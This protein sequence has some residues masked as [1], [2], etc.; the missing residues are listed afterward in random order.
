MS[1]LQRSKRILY[2]DLARRISVAPRNEGGGGGNTMSWSSSAAS[3]S[4]RTRSRSRFAA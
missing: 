1:N 2:S 3:A 4:A